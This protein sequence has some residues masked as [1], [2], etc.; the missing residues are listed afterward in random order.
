MLD[1]HFAGH[2]AR[3]SSCL[4][5]ILFQYARKVIMRGS[6]VLFS[7]RKN[8]HYAWLLNCFN[9]EERSFCFSLNF[10]QMHHCRLRPHVLSYSAPC[11]TLRGPMEDLPSSNGP[12]CRLVHLVDSHH[13]TS[14]H[15]VHTVFL[16]VVHVYSFK[17]SVP[18]VPYHGPYVTC[19]SCCPL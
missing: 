6:Y 1:G 11:V 18:H 12:S 9:T 17:S 10:Y 15:I 19:V 16:F 5:L 3:R 13:H 4:V 8:C 14:S 7:L 2:F